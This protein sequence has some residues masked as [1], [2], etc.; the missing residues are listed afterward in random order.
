[1]RFL[2]CILY[3]NSSEVVT[4]SLLYSWFKKARSAPKR[5]GSKSFKRSFK[6]EARASRIRSAPYYI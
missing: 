6:R 1:M 3:I 5:F 4:I 2:L